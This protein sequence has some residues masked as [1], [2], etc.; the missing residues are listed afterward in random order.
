MDFSFVGEP[1][2]ADDI[3]GAVDGCPACALAVIRATK[4]N[5]IPLAPAWVQYDYQEEARAYWRTVGVE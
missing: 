2:T 4:I 3:L 5:G 1:F